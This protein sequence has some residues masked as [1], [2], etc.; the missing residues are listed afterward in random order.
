MRRSRQR[1][2]GQLE[3]L[4]PRCVLD[5]TVVFNEIMYNP[6]G[7]TETLEFIEL[8][9]QQA[10]NMDLS[11]WRLDGGV[12]FTFAEGTIVPGGGY[13]VIASDVA[14][15]QTATGLTGIRG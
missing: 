6:P 9:N 2:L 15:L 5:S 4:E 10:I 1:R 14:A 3:T 13:L 7:T 8:H 12:N 11:G